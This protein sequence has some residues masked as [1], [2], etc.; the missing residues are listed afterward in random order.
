MMRVLTGGIM[1]H[2]DWPDFN[3]TAAGKKFA[4]NAPATATQ[5]YVGG[6]P[7][8]FTATSTANTGLTFGGGSGQCIVTAPTAGVYTSSSATLGANNLVGLLYN[9]AIVDI[10]RGTGDKTLSGSSVLSAVPSVVIGRCIVELFAGVFNDTTDLYAPFTV[11][12]T[13][14]TSIIGSVT[15]AIGDLVSIIAS[16]E[17]ALNGRLHKTGA[18]ISETGTA[19]STIQTG[20]IGRVLKAP[21]SATDSMILDFW[22]SALNIY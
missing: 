12:G 16:T 17:P 20:S 5:P 3:S 10:R 15:W 14:G 19:T 22:G 13:L 1:P 2:G 4:A 11:G 9:N 8:G 7:C 6:M 18:T 21:A